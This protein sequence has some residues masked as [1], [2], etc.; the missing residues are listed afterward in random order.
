MFSASPPTPVA[1]REGNAI[2]FRAMPVP[3][4]LAVPVGGFGSADAVEIKPPGTVV[5]RG[6]ALAEN[7]PQAMAAP[8][9][10]ADGRVVGEGPAHASA[11]HRLRAVLIDCDPAVDVPR[12]DITTTPEMIDA[13]LRRLRGMDIG[14]GIDALR[15]RGVWANRWTS[16]DL[17]AQLHA[18][19]R[20]PVDTVVCNVL[21][22]D[23][24][25]PLQ[26]RVAAAYGMEVTAG[27]LALAALTKARRAWAAVAY[28]ADPACW[29]SLRRSSAKNDLHLV[30]LRNDYPRAHPT[31]LL[32]ELADRALR[33]DR[34]PTEQGV[35]LLDTAAAAA[36][37][38]CFL[39]D[40]PMLTV[41]M[42]VRDRSL[43]KTHY[44]EVPVGAAYSD[45]LS[46]LGLRA[47]RID[48]RAG[49][50]LREQHVAASCIATG[51][52]LTLTLL[53]PAVA[54]NPDPCI[55][56]AWCVE[57][58]PVHIQPAGLLEAAQQDDPYMAHQY[59]LEACVECGICS[60]VC[61]SHLPILA[62]IRALRSEHAKKR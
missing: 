48:L 60:F 44:L 33:P 53:T 9:A 56:C 13:M 55:R 8:L 21:D 58:C 5:G 50:P 57:G 3:R 10:P 16:P 54:V 38:R 19:L 36:V 35:L 43:N 12:E 23:V 46:D 24:A 34:L 30:A 15:S 7:V 37:G 47:D 52:E 41:P 27:V 4:R 25:L 11:D 49:N 42:A 39:R 14:A 20:R 59:G 62:G 32:H 2:R 29:D 6:E 18:S 51:G 61:P 45:V 26:A 28:Y 22:E 17:L 40:E 1:T 31:L